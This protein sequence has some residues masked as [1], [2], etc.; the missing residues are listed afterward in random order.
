M[1]T[2]SL[3]CRFSR[4]PLL[5]EYQLSVYESLSM[6]VAAT[7]FNDITL[8]IFV[9]ASTWMGDYPPL[10]GLELAGNPIPIDPQGAVLVPYRGPRGSFPY[11]SAMDVINGTVEDPSVLEGAI[12][13]VGATAPGMEDLRSTPF[14]SIYPGV[15]VHANVIAGILDGNFRW[16]PA[17]TAAME[18][19]TVALFGL[20]TAL[21]LPVLSPF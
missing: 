6:A 3:P 11:V 14:G 5:Q 4:A 20:L 15:E 13:L 7:Y 19:I 10:E 8:P 9:D 12:V 17:Y 18:M 1:R 21:L 2:Y 16:E